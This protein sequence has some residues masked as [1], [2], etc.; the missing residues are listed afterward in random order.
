MLEH[1]HLKLQ[2]VAER[3][4]S[5][6]VPPKYAAPEQMPPPVAGGRQSPTLRV[7]PRQNGG[8]N[9]EDDESVTASSPIENLQPP[10]L[11]PEAAPWAMRGH[12]LATLELLR[13][14]SSIPD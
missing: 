8:E 10:I 3:P 6:T 7:P 4:F 1:I 13:G 11:Q 12:A 9:G 5:A 14:P 2:D